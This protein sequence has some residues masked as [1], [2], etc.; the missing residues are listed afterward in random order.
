MGSPRV[1]LVTSVSRMERVPV[2]LVE[3]ERITGPHD[4]INRSLE[5]LLT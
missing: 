2:L 5:D 4:I 1:F 3:E